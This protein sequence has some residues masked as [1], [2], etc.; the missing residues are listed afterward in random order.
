ME[1]PET[2]ANFKMRETIVVGVQK[3]W[4]RDWITQKSASLILNGDNII[5]DYDSTIQ[6]IRDKSSPLLSQG[7]QP[8]TTRINVS[9]V[10]LSGT[11]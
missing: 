1:S 6:H 10:R 7:E 9:V 11:D 4:R 2:P 3:Q 8:P 5:R